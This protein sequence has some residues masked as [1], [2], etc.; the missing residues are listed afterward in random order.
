MKPARKAKKT[1]K[2]CGEKYIGTS[3]SKWC[4]DCRP[5]M[6]KKLRY[7]C[8][9]KGTV[10]KCPDCGKDYYVAHGNMRRCRECSDNKGSIKQGERYWG[11][12]FECEICGAIGHRTG[13]K[14][15]VCQEPCKSDGRLIQC[16]CCDEWKPYSEFYDGRA[17]LGRFVRRCRD[18]ARDEQNKSNAKKGKPLHMAR[19]NRKEREG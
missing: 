8:K 7:T 2:C 19:M 1:C 18:C 14:Q 9:R 10:E 5:I 17:N 4:P 16:R 6:Y 13:T 11:S 3:R 12:E 15:R